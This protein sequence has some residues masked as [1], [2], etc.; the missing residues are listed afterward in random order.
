[1]GRLT[2]W[3]ASRRQSRRSARA[4]QHKSAG[5]A[6]R[7]LGFERYEERIALS[8]NAAI[9]VSP[10]EPL[11]F[12]NL[13]DLREGGWIAYSNNSYGHVY[14]KMSGASFH[15]NAGSDNA[16]LSSVTGAHH[17]DLAVTSL[18]L[19]PAIGRGF[20]YNLDSSGEFF[21]FSATDGRVV[22]IP[23]PAGPGGN[24]GGQIAMTPFMGPATLGLPSTGDS[25]YA[26][27]DRPALQPES[28]GAATDV[29]RATPADSLRGRAVVYE[30]AHAEGGL[31]GNRDRLGDIDSSVANLEQNESWVE[32]HA[33]SYASH[34]ESSAVADSHTAASQMK[35]SRNVEA[36]ASRQIQRDDAAATLMAETVTRSQDAANEDVVDDAASAALAAEALA[37]QDA[38][39]EQWQKKLP[40]ALEG[41]EIAAATA[42]VQQRRVLGAAL[43][44][45]GA[46][47]V[48][49]AV[50]RHAQQ[51]SVA[52]RP[53]ERRPTSPSVL[54]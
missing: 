34:Y 47:P 32:T 52:H 24:E 42:D 49:K 43:F 9:E 21:E 48:T 25:L 13:V 37:A 44:V 30:V 29:P 41:R 50:R 53:R 22:P 38:A 33:L 3:I 16:Y 23:P 27:K 39:F 19:E 7:P 1:M 4:H 11:Y 17:S 12:V 8:T 45:L 36:H 2:S 40:A 18:G 6:T 46:I 51:D 5:T 28:V 14:L 20:D 35:P 54:E 15:L 26:S 10:I 31:N